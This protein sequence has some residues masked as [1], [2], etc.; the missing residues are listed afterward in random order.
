MGAI[1]G[2]INLGNG[3][4]FW[5]GFAIGFIAG[6]VGSSLGGM[7]APA[8]GGG[9]TVTWSIG[10]S[11]S[12]GL[13]TNGI[14]GALGLGAE[15][16]NLGDQAADDVI[17]TINSNDNSCY[18]RYLGNQ[19]DLQEPDYLVGDYR[20]IDPKDYEPKTKPVKSKLSLEYPMADPK[21]YLIFENQSMS[22]IDPTFAG[23]LAALARDHNTT[24]YIGSVSGLRSYQDT[25]NLWFAHGGIYDK[26]T[27]RFLPGP[28]F[29]YIPAY[30]GSSWH[31]NGE[32]VDA[33]SSAWI[34][35]M[36]NGNT[37]S[38]SELLKYGLFKPLSTGNG[39]P[40]GNQAAEPWHIQPIETKGI[41][42][43]EERRSFYKAYA[44]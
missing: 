32:A 9:F 7:V 34:L 2:I 1:N 13:T 37:M 25:V 5:G 18:D 20:V 15:A 35:N 23:R 14:L 38:Q 41:T 6:F 12:G 17:D 22:G 3:G 4:N 27:G 43:V 19:Y 28:N 33:G 44:Q 16:D 29:D 30:P 39:Y 31:V 26:K 42:N 10:A 11:T 24:I 21:K 40:K 8:A 36:C